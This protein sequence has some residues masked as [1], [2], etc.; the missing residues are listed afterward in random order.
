MRLRIHFIFLLFILIEIITYYIP[1][2]LVVYGVEHLKYPQAQNINQTWQFSWIK[3]AEKCDTGTYLWIQWLIIKKFILREL[4][5]HNNYL[6]IIKGENAQYLGLR[7]SIIVNSANYVKVFIL[8]SK[9][10]PRG[11]SVHRSLSRSIFKPADSWVRL[12]VSRKYPRRL[13]ADRYLMNFDSAS[14][15]EG[16]KDNLFSSIFNFILGPD[17]L[18]SAANSAI[19]I[20]CR[21]G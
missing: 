10:D 4:W 13:A 2:N 9:L 8:L 19:K 15:P 16:L 17:F 14:R 20:C 18:R 11:V 7:K 21:Y 3:L 6:K 5:S 12:I 1:L